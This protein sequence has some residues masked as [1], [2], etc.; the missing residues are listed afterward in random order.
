MLVV[1]SGQSGCQIADELLTAGRTVY[2][3]VGHC[4]WLPRRYRDR[5]LVHWLFDIGMID[6]TLDALPSPAARLM[7][8]PPVSGNDG[9]HD[10]NP[11]WLA[12]RGAM[13]LGRIEGVDGTSLRIGPGL[14]ESLAFGDDFVETFERRIDEHV[15]ETGSSAPTP[16]RRA[17]SSRFRRSASS[18]CARRAWGRCCGRTAFAPDHSWIEGVEP[19]TQGWPLHDAGASP[20]PGLYFV[21]LHW[22]QKRKS[23]LFSGVGE[24]AEHVVSAL[25]SRRCGRVLRGAAEALRGACAGPRGLD[26]AVARRRCRHERLEEVLRHVCDLVDRTRERGLVRLRRLRGARSPCARTAALRR[27]PRR[28][29]RAARSCGVS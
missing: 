27:G 12:E 13:L 18:T 3:S 28:P 25:V 7:C 15:R 4:P 5:E 29:S 11:R 6:D 14:N 19:D 26:V 17:R 10:C 9:G 23:S 16:S 21:G 20:V 8:N 1:G 22:L 2:L 24:D